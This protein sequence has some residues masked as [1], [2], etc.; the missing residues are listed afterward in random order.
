MD[1]SAHLSG[2]RSV[3]PVLTG[4]QSADRLEVPFARLGVQVGHD[5]RVQAL[6]LRHFIQ[7]RHPQAAW[8]GAVRIQL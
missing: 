3:Q 6:P 1:P 8:L 4:F 2:Q 7:S 5:G